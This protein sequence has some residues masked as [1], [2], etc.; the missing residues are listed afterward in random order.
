[1]KKLYKKLSKK[2]KKREKREGVRP[3]YIHLQDLE[4][5]L[6]KASK[7]SRKHHLR[8]PQKLNFYVKF[9]Q[10]LGHRRGANTGAYRCE[11]TKT[12]VRV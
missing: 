11:K 6:K 5:T 7:T 10:L 1:M 4:G 3:F 2:V 12:P 8:P 9:R